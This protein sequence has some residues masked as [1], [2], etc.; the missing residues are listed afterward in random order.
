MKRYTVLA[1]VLV[2]LSFSAALFADANAASDREKKVK[3]DSFYSVLQKEFGFTKADCDVVRKAG[4]SPYY[5]FKLLCIAK[6]ANKPAAVVITMAKNGDSWLDMCADFNIDYAQLMDS[7]NK[8]IIE[9]NITFPVSS[10]DES[11]KDVS[12]GVRKR[13]VK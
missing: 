9:K 10:D 4:Y 13:G 5:S 12:T 6:A 8:I 3:R 11:K 1:L 2:L 7:M